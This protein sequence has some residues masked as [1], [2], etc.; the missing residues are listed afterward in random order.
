MFRINPLLLKLLTMATLMLVLLLPLHSVESL[1]TER[2]NA[3]ASAVERVASSSGHQQRIGAAIIV[4]PVTRSWSVDGKPFS[5]IRKV[6]VLAR[7]VAIKTTVSTE[8]RHS[9]I[10]EVPIFQASISIV[11]SFPTPFLWN[12]LAAEPGVE[13]HIGQPFLFVAVS[14]LAA[15]R[16]LDGIKV[17][18]VML[19]VF[20]ATE[21]G[22]SGVAAELPP[23]VSGQTVLKQFSVELAVSGTERLQWLPLAESTVVQ[24]A[25]GWPDPAFSGTF[26]PQR[27]NVTQRGFTADWHVLQI[28][29]DFPQR[30]TDDAVTETQIER[31][32]FGVDFYQPVDMYQ[33]NYRSIHYAILL[34]AVTYLAL[35]LWSTPSGGLCIPCSTPWWARRYRSFTCCCLRSANTCPLV[36]HMALPERQ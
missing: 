21:N 29:R 27:P 3:R 1:I 19:P 31:R 32:A 13:E 2:A 9:G 34:I 35:F 24:V 10:Y 14:D 36:V 7:D 20:S 28:N 5:Q 8:I 30:W 17:D 6:R 15:I 22:L 16:L 23:I 33:Q 12:D 25:S 4:V 11:G 18:G 26:A